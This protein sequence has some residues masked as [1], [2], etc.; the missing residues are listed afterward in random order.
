MKPVIIIAIV[1]VFG[2]GFG[3]TA[4]GEEG[5]VPTWI[6]NTALWYGQGEVS[7]T[8]F[9]SALQFLINQNVIE[10]P[11]TEVSA[12]K[13]NLSDDERAQSFVVHISFVD[14]GIDETF[15]SFSIFSHV[16]NRLPDPSPFA[17]SGIGSQGDKPQ[18]SL[19]SL[20]SEDK[21][22]IYDLIEQILSSPKKPERFPVSVD[23]LSGSGNVIQ[24][25][26][27]RDCYPI[28]YDVYVEENRDV[29][30]LSETD[31]NE[32]REKITFECVGYNLKN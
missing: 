17:T 18:F 26:N 23:I 7:D 9:I 2:I 29:Y 10:V 24:T 32:I 6:K 15:Y 22:P 27:Y 14:L 1:V 31:D 11:I 20:V 28:Q 12:T 19:V 30:R 3:L 4:S 5:I 21:K 8:E 25:W 16:D 13:V